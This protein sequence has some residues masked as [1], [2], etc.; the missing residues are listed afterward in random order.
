MEKDLFQKSS[1]KAYFEIEMCL[2]HKKKKHFAPFY[3]LAR[4][5]II[6]AMLI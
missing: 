3:N 4:G 6:F 1:L 5:L 2:A